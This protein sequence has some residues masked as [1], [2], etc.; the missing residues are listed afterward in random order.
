MTPI[1]ALGIEF[2]GYFQENSTNRE[3]SEMGAQLANQHRLGRALL[4]LRLF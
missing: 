4:F 3:E 1:P 2:N